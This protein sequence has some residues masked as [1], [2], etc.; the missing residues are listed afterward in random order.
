MLRHAP[1][2]LIALALAASSTAHASC[3]DDLPAEEQRACLEAALSALQPAPAAEPLSSIGRATLGGNYSLGG[4]LVDWS[5][6]RGHLSSQPASEKVLAKSRR[7]TTSSIV[8]ASAGG[9]FVLGGLASA[10]GPWYLGRAQ[11]TAFSMLGGATMLGV[12]LA[13]RSRARDLRGEAIDVYNLSVASVDGGPG[14]TL[15]GRF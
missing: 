10:A 12:S 11:V 6:T 5:A 1:L 14:L 7:K 8:L 2:T 3:P 4:E 13:K 15:A 9:A